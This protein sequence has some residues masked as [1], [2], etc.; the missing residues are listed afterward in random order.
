M[1]VPAHCLEAP[2]WTGIVRVDKSIEPFHRL[3]GDVEQQLQRCAPGLYAMA[4][5]WLKHAA[6]AE[7][8]V[9]ETFLRVLQN[10]DRYRPE[11]PFEHWV[12]TICANVVRGY[13]RRKKRR[14][15]VALSPALAGSPPAE[16]AL[17]QQ[18]DLERIAR[19]IS[20]LDPEFRAP[21]MLRRFYDIPPRQIAELLGIPVEHVRV[22]LYRAVQKVREAA[23]SES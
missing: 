22:R 18:E 11:A 7:D 19:A 16:Q 9:Q 4:Q 1:V 13:A 15:E 20:S 8:A 6:D 17:E 10:L 23:G 2:G 5:A 3:A 21:L 14:R 12:F